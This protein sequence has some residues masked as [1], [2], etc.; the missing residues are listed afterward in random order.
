MTKTGTMTKKLPEKN[1]DSILRILAKNWGNILRVA[2]FREEK[3]IPI[4]SV[5]PSSS[6]KAWINRDVH[7]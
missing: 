7:F 1:S 6:M 5:H 4:Q 3:N 2:N